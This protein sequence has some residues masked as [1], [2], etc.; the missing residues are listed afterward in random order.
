LQALDVTLLR[1]LLIPPRPV[2][3]FVAMARAQPKDD[4]LLQVDKVFSLLDF[5]VYSLA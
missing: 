1:G 2:A 3:T 5:L 4:A